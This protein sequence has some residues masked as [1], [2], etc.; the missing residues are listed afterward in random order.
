MKAL[1]TT[2]EGW[3]LRCRDIIYCVQGEV[4]QGRCLVVADGATSKLATELGYCTEPP[5]GIC[6]RAFVEGGTHNTNFDG[7]RPEEAHTLHSIAGV[8]K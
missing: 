8:L 4:V 3:A 1:L 6:S 2:H 7:E 5:K